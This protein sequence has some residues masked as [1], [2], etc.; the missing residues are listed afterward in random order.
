MVVV[1]FVQSWLLHPI[2]LW[3]LVNLSSEY[4]FCSYSSIPRCHRRIIIRGNVNILS[5]ASRFSFIYSSI[6][7][8]QLH[9]FYI[10]E[11]ERAICPKPILPK[12]ECTDGWYAEVCISS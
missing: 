1:L 4:S 5:K 10:L 12:L 7:Y 2:Q 11:F 9:E 8:C 6:S 3:G